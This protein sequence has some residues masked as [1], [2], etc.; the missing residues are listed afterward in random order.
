MGFKIKIDT[1]SLTTNIRRDL[2]KY[3]QEVDYDQIGEHLV[4]EIQRKGYRMIMEGTKRSEGQTD[5]L[6]EVERS[7]LK[8][9]LGA[10]DYRVKEDNLKNK[11]LEIGIFDDP[12]KARNLTA[13]EYGT[14][15]TP[16]MAVIRTVIPSE[17]EKV[18]KFIEG[19][20]KLNPREGSGEQS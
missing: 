12:E 6:D 10:V 5:R 18:S 20:M 19:K 4:G 14:M 9:V 8:E 16:E 13:M 11:Y 17:E 2:K 3:R 15:K 1:R 7:E